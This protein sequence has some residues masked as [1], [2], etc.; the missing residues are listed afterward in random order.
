[1]RILRLLGG[2]IAILIAGIASPHAQDTSATTSSAISKSLHP[3]QAPRQACCVHYA[4]RAARKQETVG[5]K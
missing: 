3:P 4:T 5:L 1:M 2:I